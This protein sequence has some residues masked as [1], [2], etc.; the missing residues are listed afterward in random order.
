M[1]F[2]VKS[3]C[4]M[5]HLQS[6]F[7]DPKCTS[8]KCVLEEKMFPSHP[9][10]HT[11][12]ATTKNKSFFLE[13]LQIH[14]FFPKSRKH[15]W[16]RPGVNLH[17]F[18]TVRFSLFSPVLLIFLRKFRFFFY[19]S[20]PCVSVYAILCACLGVCVHVLCVCMS[21]CVF[22]CVCAYVLCLMH[23]MCWV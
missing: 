21:G 4:F 10:T 11:L 9:H 23:L 2:S 13:L 16:I 15:K 18:F 17:F 3:L 7:L 8:C 1:F 6:R 14:I 12:S 5:H 22:V 20:C 19:S